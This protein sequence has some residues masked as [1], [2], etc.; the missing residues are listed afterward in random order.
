MVLAIYK[1]LQFLLN[2]VSASV[3][4]PTSVSHKHI[5]RLQ[6][7]KILL[8]TCIFSFLW[9]GG[10]HGYNSYP[11]IHD[12]PAFGQKADGKFVC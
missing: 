6:L 2:F 10:S 5:G 11:Q 4:V 7:Y 1:S 12:Q 8:L 3:W 9:I